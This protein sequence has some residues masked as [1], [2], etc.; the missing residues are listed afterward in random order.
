[1]VAF[2]AK[3]SVRIVPFMAKRVRSIVP[4]A[5]QHFRI[6]VCE[7]A[8]RWAI[9]LRT[10]E[11]TWPII[12][13]RSLQL[14]D[15]ALGGGATAGSSHRGQLVV[16]ALDDAS[17]TATLSRVATWTT[18][19]PAPVVLIAKEGMAEQEEWMWREAGAAEVLTSPTDLRKVSRILL[20]LCPGG[21][22]SALDALHGELT[23]RLPFAPALG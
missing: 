7:R 20:R 2:L 10:L 8:P 6:V 19:E 23:A 12:E 16:V 9:L 11:L 17:A 21:P 22:Q 18:S 5:S 1:L 3:D 4:Q 15:E 13:T 14:A